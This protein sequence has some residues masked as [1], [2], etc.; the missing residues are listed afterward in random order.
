MN[1]PHSILLQ[2]DY[3]ERG[4]PIAAN[5]HEPNK[6][7]LSQTLTEDMVMNFGPYKNDVMLIDGGLGLVGGREHYIKHYIKHDK[8]WC[9]CIKSGFCMSG[10]MSSVKS[11]SI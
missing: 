9:F 2:E 10:V 6:Q 11:T 3:D 4:V 1:L 7:Q 5:Y 8:I